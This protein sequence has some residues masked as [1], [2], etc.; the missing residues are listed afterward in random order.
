VKRGVDGCDEIFHVAADYRFW[1]LHPDELYETN[2]KGT[3]HLLQAALRAGVSKFIHTSTVGTFGP[4]CNPYKQSKW[5]AE[6]L[7]LNY[8]EKGL[9]VVVVSPSTPIGPWDRKPTPTGKLI[10]DYMTGRL[11]AYVHTGLNFIHIQDVADGHI[12][13]A[14]KGRI[15]ERYILGNANLSL[16][17]FLTLLGEIAGRSRPGFR[18]PYSLAW[19]MGWISTKYSD[20]ISRKPPFIPLSAVKMSR[21]WM[22]FDS[23]KAVRDLGLPQTPIEVAAA[24][25]LDWFSRNDYFH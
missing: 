3:N 1:T 18:I 12:L 7:A 25:A 23:S 24:D 11:P 8:V 5:E 17:Q 20:W 4:L 2:V 10:V 13:A 19:I 21:Q 6:K 15:G 16:V 22:F 14:E 9:P